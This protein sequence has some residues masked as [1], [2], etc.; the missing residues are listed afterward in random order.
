[1]DDKSRRA[2]VWSSDH[3]TKSGDERGCRRRA[4]KI[5]AEKWAGRTFAAAADIATRA[6][7]MARLQKALAAAGYAVEI[8]RFSIQRDRR[9][10][11][12][13]AGYARAM[14]SAGLI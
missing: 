14:A 5:A 6:E 2:V 7:S 12:F 10:A 9:Q 11:Q 4:A 3:M 1:M 13:E 8:G